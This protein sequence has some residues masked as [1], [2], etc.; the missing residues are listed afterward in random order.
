MNKTILSIALPVPLYRLFDYYCDLPKTSLQNGCR[1]IVPFGNRKMVGII[2]E[3]KSETAQPLHK[4]KAICEHLEIEPVLSKQFLFYCKWLSDYYHY[5]L[6]EVCFNLLPNLLKKPS[7]PELKAEVHYRLN[8][9]SKINLKS[10]SRAPKQ[11]AVI[12]VFQQQ[13]NH[14]L[15]TSA[16]QV[17]QVPSALLKILLS[18]QIITAFTPTPILNNHPVT[19]LTLN[20][21][22]AAAVNMIS[23]ALNQFQTFLLEGVTASGKTEVYL[24]IID[25]VI[26]Q[27]KQAIVLV[28]EISL[29]PQTINRFMT[30]FGNICL[31]LHSGLTDRERLAGWLQAKTN[32][33]KIIIGT[34]S[35][36]FTPLA[37]PGIIIIDE[38]HDLSFKQQEGFRYS[39]RDF[40]IL[41]AQT[42]EIP[43]VLGSATPSLESLLN[44]SKRY[45]LLQ[46]AKRSNAAPLPHYQLIDLRNKSLQAG[47]SEPLLKKIKQHLQQ[48][49]QVLLF[50]NRRGFSPSLFCHQCGWIGKCQRCNINYTLHQSQ[51]KLICHHCNS[52]RALPKLCLQCHSNEL[53]A[54]G[55]GTERIEE[56]LQQYFPTHRVL[57]VDRD[58]TR[59]KHALKQLLDEINQGLPAILVGTQMLAKGH[60]FPN[61]TLVG[62]IDADSGFYS[63]DFR[64]IERM[65]QLVVQVAGRAGRAKQSGE[66]LIQTHQPENPLLL[67]LIQ[68]GYHTFAENLLK[69]RAL[70]HLP[71]YSYF[72]LL[73][74]ESTQS[75]LPEQFLSQIKTLL[76]KLPEISQVEALGPTPAI[77]AKRAGKFRYQLLL[78]A[79]QRKPLQQLLTRLMLEIESLKTTRQVRWSLDVDPLEMF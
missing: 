19:H 13:T 36:I 44:A 22:Q 6:G 32:Q 71:P 47:M 51:K 28:P 77:M 63:S 43:I 56:T 10:L 49:N 46:L 15:S 24:Q 38:E 57:R 12:D 2:W 76:E 65:G 74:A 21:E 23:E 37:N 61:V 35:A 8:D 72:A 60:H 53:I 34:R 7:L 14:T 78:K 3:I 39:A 69:E 5:P 30:R 48:H 62:I 42:E 33:I 1:V 27:N 29:T 70:C 66:V 55:T 54:L 20:V 64:A 58:S 26:Q 67:E 4:L 45:T 59:K 31:A 16:L 50:L 41:R 40:A 73:R 18:K 52:H 68:Q 11:L 9:L 75:H 17:Q 79:E 25:K